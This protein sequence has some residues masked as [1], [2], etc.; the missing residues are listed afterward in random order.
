VRERLLPGRKVEIAPAPLARRGRG[1]AMSF[2]AE[3]VHSDGGLGLQDH[4][5]NIDAFAGGEAARRWRERYACDD[6]EGLVWLNFWRTTNM[7][8][9]LEHMPL[10]LCD[11]I[12]LDRRDL[13]RTA[14][15]GLAAQGRETHHLALRFNAD[16][17]WFYYPRMKCDELIVF[18]LAEVWKTCSPVRNCFHTAFRKPVSPPDVEERQSCELRVSVLVLRN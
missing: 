16:Q 4:V 13:V 7:T 6:V 12:S 15:T 8:G 18:T 1:T 5:H 2:Y 14:M 10:A 3:G 11:P 17:R 9:A